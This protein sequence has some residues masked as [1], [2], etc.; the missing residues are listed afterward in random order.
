MLGDT[1]R[2]L[3]HCDPPPHSNDILEAVCA[4]NVLLC[5]MVVHSWYRSAWMC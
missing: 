1:C 3:A 2:T 5:V 4:V